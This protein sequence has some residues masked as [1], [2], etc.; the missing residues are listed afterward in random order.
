MRDKDRIALVGLHEI[1]HREITLVLQLL[2]ALPLTLLHLPDLKLLQ[3]LALSVLVNQLDCSQLL[4]CAQDV[5]VLFLPGA[6]SR[7]GFLCCD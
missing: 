4:L 6:L 1:S 2:H 7:V 3:Q 5:V